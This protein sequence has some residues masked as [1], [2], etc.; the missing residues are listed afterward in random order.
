MREKTG[1]RLQSAH[2]A[3]RIF[4]VFLWEVLGDQQGKFSYAPHVL[5]KGTLSSQLMAA[6]LNPQVVLKS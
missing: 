5:L 6:P 3:E 4:H 1:D 2:Q